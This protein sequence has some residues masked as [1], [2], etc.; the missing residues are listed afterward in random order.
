MRATEQTT[1]VAGQVPMSVHRHVVV[2]G[3]DHLGADEVLDAGESVL[4]VATRAGLTE[5]IDL[6]RAPD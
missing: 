5:F 3:V 2:C 6:A 1:A 4:V